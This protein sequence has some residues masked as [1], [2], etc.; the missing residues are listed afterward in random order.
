M[1]PP[2]LGKPIDGPAFRDAIHVAVFPAFAE[3][4]L[5]PGDALW[6]M[7]PRAG[8]AY[9]V[10]VCSRR[11]ADAFVDPFLADPLPPGAKFYACLRPGT[12]TSLRHVYTHPAFQVT[13]PN[14]QDLGHE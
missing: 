10:G 8:D 5:N 13:A 9:K 14:R 4:P 7:G 1:E 3:V 11:A 6:L 12:V 2:L